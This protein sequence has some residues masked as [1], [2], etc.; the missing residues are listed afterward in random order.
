VTERKVLVIEPDCRRAQSWH[1]ILRG[2]SCQPIVVADITAIE[3]IAERL[4][5]P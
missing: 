4:R 5:V 1:N 3:R 2:L